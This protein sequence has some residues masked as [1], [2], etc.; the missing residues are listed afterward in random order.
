MPYKHRELKIPR[1]LDRRIKLTPEQKIEICLIYT[2]EN[3]SQR[4]LA[5]QF[6][7]SRRTISFIVHPEQYE[8]N[9][10]RR[11]ERGGEKQYYD[12]AKNTQA[13]REH[14]QYKQE[15]YKENK[16]TEEK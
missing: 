7:V 2:L 8:E 9:K 4:E 15:L 10:K 3:I 13:R 16:L 5:R 14:R 11:R 1:E 6:N 12:T